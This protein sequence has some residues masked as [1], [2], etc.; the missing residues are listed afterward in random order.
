MWLQHHAET[1]TNTPWV[2]G[3]GG[4][5]YSHKIGHSDFN[6]SVG[7]SAGYA[8]INTG[9]FQKKEVNAS[10][11]EF[12]YDYAVLKTD[13]LLRE[14]NSGAFTAPYIEISLPMKI[15]YQLNRL[16]PYTGIE[17]R[18]SNFLNGD[19]TKY[20]NYTLNTDYFHDLGLILGFDC[21]FSRHWGISLEGIQSLTSKSNNS[22]NGMFPSL[23]QSEYY[24][25]N[26]KMNANLIYSF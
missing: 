2:E 20:N 11:T 8:K 9:Y 25:K 5:D 16:R 12:E 13:I 7:L 10:L 1:I 17:Y 14:L 3:H 18:Y 4:I 19:F 26:L 15:G 23:G 24:F 22:N 21:Y 6:W